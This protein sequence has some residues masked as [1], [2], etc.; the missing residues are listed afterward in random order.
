VSPIFPDL[1]SMWRAVCERKLMKFVFAHIKF[2]YYGEQL[3]TILSQFRLTPL[4]FISMSLF[5]LLLGLP[6]GR[7]SRGYPTH[8]IL[9]AQFY[10]HNIRSVNKSSSV[11]LCNI[12]NCSNT[13]NFLGPNIFLGTLF[14]KNFTLCSFLEVRN[15]DSHPYKGKGKGEVPVLN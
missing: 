4:E 7:F 15:H 10:P 14:S 1:L 8:Q 3:D 5:H 9:N 13:S 11:L 12:I 2:G 6:S